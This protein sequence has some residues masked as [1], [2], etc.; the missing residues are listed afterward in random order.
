MSGDR[1][2]TVP[3]GDALDREIARMVMDGAPNKAIARATGLAEGT[4][5]W[6]LH[7]RYARLGVSS[8]TTFAMALRDLL[9]EG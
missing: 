8:R 6:R 9:D 7:R 5:K 1:D 3:F 4:V 2:T